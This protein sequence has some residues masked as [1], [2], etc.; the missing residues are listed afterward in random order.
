MKCWWMKLCASATWICGPAF[1]SGFM[2]KEVGQGTGLGLAVVHGI[3]Q[4]YDGAILVQ[5]AL[6]Q[7]TEFQVLLPARLEAVDGVNSATPPPPPSNGE[8]IL[9]VDDEA[10]LI[11]VLKRLLMRAGYKVTAHADPLAAL[12]DFISRPADIH[13]V[14]TDL[15]MPGMNG[16]ELAS[17]IFTIQPDLPVVIATGF[18]GDLITPA[19]LAELPNIRKVVEKPLSPEAITRLIAELL[20][21]GGPA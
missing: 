6:G 21:P 15:T 11:K 5:T 17:Q 7:G 19:Q 9:L 16:L 1:M 12:Q 10:A 3:V 14:L 20:H 18:S 8:H 4:N 13:L 2:S